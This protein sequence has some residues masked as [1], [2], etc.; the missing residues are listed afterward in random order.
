VTVNWPWVNPSPKTG[1]DQ[2]DN[3]TG[4]KT[5]ELIR[6]AIKKKESFDMD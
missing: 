6:R 5:I 4:A 3:K 2:S 1:F